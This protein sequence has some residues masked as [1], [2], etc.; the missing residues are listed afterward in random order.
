MLRALT[1]IVTAAFIGPAAGP[2]SV[3]VWRARHAVARPLPLAAV[4]LTGVPLRHAQ[5]L[6]ARYL[7]SLDPDRLLAYGH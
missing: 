4:R 1:V 6:D 7:L 2:A 5:D 3:Q